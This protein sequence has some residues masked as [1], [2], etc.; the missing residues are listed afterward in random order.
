M[1]QSPSIIN[2]KYHEY[3]VLKQILED[4]KKE[5]EFKEKLIEVATQGRIERF[6]QE[7]QAREIKRK[8]EEQRSEVFNI[9][10]KKLPTITAKEWDQVLKN[11]NAQKPITYKK[12]KKL[13]AIEDKPEKAL[14]KL[15]LS[16]DEISADDLSEE[17][18]D[19][20]KDADGEYV[21]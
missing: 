11:A 6:K 19:Y 8:I 18:D 7:Q 3:V 15:T 1:T 13:L 14:A 21:N 10:A 12:A 16:E 17:G 2:A 20:K 5:E 9:G 4:K